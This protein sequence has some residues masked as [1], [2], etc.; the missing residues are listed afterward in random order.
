MLL[1]MVSVLFSCSQESKEVKPLPQ[2]LKQYVGAY[3]V[4]LS[5]KS[6]SSVNS[7]VYY[8]YENLEAKYALYKYDAV[9]GA[10]QDFARFGKW[11]ATD[12]TLEISVR[13]RSG[14][15]KEQFI[16]EDGIWID[17]SSGRYL[18]KQK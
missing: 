16:K 18:I 1:I 17:E 2:H 6:S 13:G 9:K 10:K 11:Y 4:E 15:I 5:G 8:L 3:T 14:M 7:E 12:S